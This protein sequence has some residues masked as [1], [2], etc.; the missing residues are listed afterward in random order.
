MARRKSD[1][2]ILQ[3]YAGTADAMVTVLDVRGFE[4]EAKLAEQLAQA[5]TRRYEQVEEK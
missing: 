3:T 2:E 5:L 4:A 1:V